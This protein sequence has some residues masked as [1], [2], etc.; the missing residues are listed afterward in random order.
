MKPKPKRITTLDDLSY[1]PKNANLGTERGKAALTKSLEKYGAGRSVL[2]DRN[3]NIIAGNK[4]VAQAKAIG[5]RKIIVVPTDGTEVI[6]VQRTDLDLSDK[7]AKALAVADNRVAE[8]DLDWSLS[9]LEEL[10]IDLGDFFTSDELDDLRPSVDTGAV[11]GNL[12]AQ[13]LVPPFSVL[14]ARQG[15]W[16]ER[17]RAWLALGIESELGRGAGSVAAA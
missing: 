7:K 14:D 15:Y 3:G 5:L 12:A 13:F 17:K 8:L 2:I 6:A 4:T 9:R 16:Q 10:N 1:D 11:T